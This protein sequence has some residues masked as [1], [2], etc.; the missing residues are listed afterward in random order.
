MRLDNYHV[1]HY[2]FHTVLHNR[3][4]TLNADVDMHYLVAVLVVRSLVSL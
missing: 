2:P 4:I 3:N 1:S